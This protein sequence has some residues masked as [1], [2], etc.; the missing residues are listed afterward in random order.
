[1]IE[2][3]NTMGFHLVY[4]HKDNYLYINENR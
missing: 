2:Q 1:M 3:L 4:H